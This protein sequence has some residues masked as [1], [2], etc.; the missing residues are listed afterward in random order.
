MRTVWDEG[1]TAD[2]RVEVAEAAD[3]T[4]VTVTVHAP[5]GTTRTVPAPTPN[6]DRS[7]WDVPVLLDAPG[8]WTIVAEVTGG[9]AGVRRYRLRVRPAGPVVPRGRSYATTEDLARWLDDAPPVDAE[10]QLARASEVVDA[11]A[12]TA[13][14]RFDS[15]GYPTAQ[16]IR[17]GFRDA[18]CAQVAFMAGGHGNE[19]GTAGQYSQVSIGSVNLSGRGE[20][21][22]QGT[23]TAEGIPV[24]PG[25]L[26]AL[27]ACGALPGTVQ[28]RG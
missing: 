2:V 17:D 1:S 18:V 4:V 22:R 3:N 8:L 21:Q 15:D 25:A 5:D 10:R 12:L 11:L 6:V 20:S 9:G 26:A 13:V 16:A 24:A 27:R 14:Y 7:E 23:T 19:H 28:V